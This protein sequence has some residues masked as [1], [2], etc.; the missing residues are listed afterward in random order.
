M[1]VPMEDVRL[2]NPQMEGGTFSVPPTRRG[3]FGRVREL[4]SRPS[5]VA[6]VGLRRIGKTVLVQQLLNELLTEGREVFYFSFDQERYATEESLD[7]M[8][9]LALE[10]YEEPVV[11]LD[12]I[13]RVD[14]W[15]GVVK[16]YI[17]RRGVKFILSGSQS[18]A[19]SKGKESL[20][21]RLFELHL[22]PLQFS[23]F[24]EMSGSDPRPLEL[25]L[26]RPER[27]LVEWRDSGL[28][29]KFLLKGGFPE[30]VGEE[31][32]DYIRRYV[33]SNCIEKIIFED[34]PKPF[35][36]SNEHALFSLWQLIA[37]N[38]SMTF[39]PVNLEP[40]IGLSK[41][42]IA[43]YL[44][45]LEMAYLVRSVHREGSVQSR[46]RKGRKVYPVTPCISSLA[47]G[48]E[49]SPGQLAETAVC[50]RLVNGLATE[51]FFHRDARK[52]EVD[53]IADGIPVEVKYQR[54]IVPGDLHN[55]LQYLKFRDLDTGIVVTR[56]TAEVV[57]RV[58]KRVLLVPLDMFLQL[59]A[60]VERGG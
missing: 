44:F 18:L 11:A 23:E 31:D 2:Y 6:V 25:S 46:M 10:L 9:K 52:R 5:A 19:I 43:N 30:L 4:V 50:D 7:G 26:S 54:T 37:R 39:V 24:I 41:D 29:E 59:G 12:E 1:L 13:G 8:V 28:L 17:D 32:E 51:V 38:P 58:G 34:L 60:I 47:G 22:P 45:Y 53:F 21:G 55:V 27:A 49:V 42:T 33:L 40:V 14:R 48:G 15:A 36:I 56:D 16:K 3:L 35:G 20:A 57:E